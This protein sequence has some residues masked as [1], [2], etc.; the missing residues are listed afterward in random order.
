MGLVTVNLMRLCQVFWQ[1]GIIGKS[2]C[3]LGKQT[4]EAELSEVICLLNRMNISYDRDLLKKMQNKAEIDAY[5]FFKLIGFGE[6]HAID[7]DESDGAD[8]LFDLN[9][10]TVPREL[11]R[12][13]D[14]VLDGG[15]LEHVFNIAQAMQNVSGM[16]KDDGY[17][18]HLSPVGG[19][20]D[21]GFYSFSP[22]FFTDFYT[23]NGYRV[24]EINIG[25][26]E[27]RKAYKDWK[28]IYSMDCRLFHDFIEIDK[29]IKEMLNVQTIGRMLLWCVAKKEKTDSIKYPIQLIYDAERKK[30][31]RKDIVSNSEINYTKLVAYLG[32]NEGA[33]IALFGAGSICSQ[34]ISEVYK[35]GIQDAIACVFDSDVNKAGT[36]FRGY[37]ICYPNRMNLEKVNIIVICT[38]KYCEEIY[39]ELIKCCNV[40]TIIR[41]ITEF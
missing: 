26:Y 33:G 11:Q 38:T 7:F 21:H 40:N 10:Q 8:I 2:I 29:Y 15:T 35:H 22:T 17:V 16:V 36:I 30:E 41:K 27:D 3:M 1:R 23:Q 5:D 25:F 12:R 19:Y 37:P 24:E 34:T 9:Q 13:F 18:I 20:I 31:L 14:Y 28:V 6:I 32:E 39:K 4:I